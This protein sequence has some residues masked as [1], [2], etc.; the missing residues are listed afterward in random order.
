[1]RVEQPF[2][3][4]KILRPLGDRL[5]D[6]QIFDLWQSHAHTPQVVP[7]AA[8]NSLYFKWKATQYDVYVDPGGLVPE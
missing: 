8:T 3:I 5:H 1:M 4:A 2:D 7:R 6:Q